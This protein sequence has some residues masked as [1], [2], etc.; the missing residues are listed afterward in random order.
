MSLQKLIKGNIIFL[1]LWLLSTGICQAQLHR[2]TDMLPA[3]D[4]LGRVLPTHEE[5]KAERPDR[6]VGL[7]YWT[8]HTNFAVEF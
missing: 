5:V 1:A 4:A 7:F 8:W 3:T 2:Y 6:F